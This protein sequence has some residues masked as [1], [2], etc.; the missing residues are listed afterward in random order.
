MRNPLIV[1]TTG[2]LNAAQRCDLEF[3]MTGTGT[4]DLGIPYIRTELKGDWSRFTGRVNVTTTNATEGEFRLNN[5]FDMP[6]AAVTLGNKVNANHVIAVPPEGIGFSIGE[7]AGVAGSFLKGAPTINAGRIFTYTVGGKNTDAT[8]A[9]II[10]EQAAGATTA[11]R[12]IGTGTWT[13]SGANTHT[14]STTVATGT[15]KISSPGSITNSAATDVLS[16]G[17]LEMAGGSLATGPVSILAAGT[18]KGSGTVKGPVENDG[19]ILGTALGTPAITG[20]LINNGTVRLTEGSTIRVSGTFTNNGVLNIIGGSQTLPANFV[21]NGVVMDDSLLQPVET[22]VAS[23]VFTASILS[24]TG[25]DYQLQH[26][27]DL[28][29]GTWQDVGN[30][31][32]GTGA[33]ITLSQPVVV[34]ANKSFYRI[35]ISP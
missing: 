8:F 18:L 6:M 24:R 27:A 2:R 33:V 21:N 4:L 9:G 32:S 15:L 28:V 30:P 10:T 31:V 11:I 19:L 14:G 26:R 5:L 22:T 1:E 25:F 29:G 13:L 20:N 12:K 34:G 7:V 17:T 23:G 3:S 16:G 35:S